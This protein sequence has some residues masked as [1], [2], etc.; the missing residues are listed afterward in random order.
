MT[1]LRVKQSKAC[2]YIPIRNNGSELS[3]IK[4]ISGAAVTSYQISD[5]GLMMILPSNPAYKN[6]ARGANFVAFG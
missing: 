5:S 3:S 4:M 6:S 1:V 2:S